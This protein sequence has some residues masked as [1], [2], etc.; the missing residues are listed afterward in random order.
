MIFSQVDGNYAK[1]VIK[2][3]SDSNNKRKKLHSTM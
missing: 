3:V 1:I 2:F